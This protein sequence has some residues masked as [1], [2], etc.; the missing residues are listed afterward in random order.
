M[1]FLIH[2]RRAV[3]RIKP[4]VV[5]VVFADSVE[6]ELVFKSFALGDIFVTMAETINLAGTKRGGASA[7]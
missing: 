4:L 1:A 5:N 7:L 6:E 3:L 2:L